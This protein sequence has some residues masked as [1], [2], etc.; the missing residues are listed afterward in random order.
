MAHWEEPTY[1]RL[2]IAALNHSDA[3]VREA[4]ADALLWEQPVAAEKRLLE[5]SQESDEEAAIAALNTLCYCASKEIILTLDELRKN[6]QESIRSE[7]ENAFFH[8]REEFA[9]TISKNWRTEAAKK[10]FLAW[11]EPLANCVSANENVECRLDD[12]DLANETP[13]SSAPPQNA[14]VNSTSNSF[15]VEQI[16]EDL[17][18]LDAKWNEKLRRY[19][20]IEHWKDMETSDRNRLSKF[21]SSSNDPLV[22]EIAAGACPI[23]NDWQT[24]L[25][26]L[27]DPLVFIRKTASYYSRDLEPNQLI[28]ERLWEVFQDDATTG[29]FATESLQ[30]Y[31]I[32]ARDIN[33]EV[34][35]FDLARNDPRPSV[36]LESI[37]QLH[38][39][40]AGDA[41]TQL[42]PIL[43]EPPSN[44]WSV[45]IALLDALTDLCIEIPSLEHLRNVDNL[46]LQEA[47]AEALEK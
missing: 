47:I 25:V 34:L 35:L 9:S 19:A 42:K 11:L 20:H 4:A 31:L 46:Y 12:E 16:I 29:C 13:P 44:T 10:R 32:H 7:Y 26:L 15:S 41:I 45:H 18:Q 36:R 24:M 33:E 1:Q 28:A 21:L 6:G 27:H 37:Y 43:L 40:K 22:R 2:L 3:S 8:V 23:W 14:K 5:I 17:S 38:N 39:L 30:S